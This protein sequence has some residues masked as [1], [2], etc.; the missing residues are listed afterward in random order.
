[1]PH[2]RPLLGIWIGNAAALAFASA[3]TTTIVCRLDWAHVQPSTLARPRTC[4]PASR[5]DE[6]CAGAGG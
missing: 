5:A 6:D 3:W 1:M 2:G 4:R